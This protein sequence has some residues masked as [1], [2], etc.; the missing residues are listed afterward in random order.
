MGKSPSVRELK[1]KR[2]VEGLIKALEDG[3][4][5]VRQIAAKALGEIGDK[6][7]VEPL[8]RLLE[9]E[10]EYGVVL[11]TAVDALGN[12]GDKRAV[13]PLTRILECQ[14]I[15]KA[16][17][18]ALAR[19]TAG[20]FRMKK[21]ECPICGAKYDVWEGRKLSCEHCGAYL[22]VEQGQLVE[23]V[24]EK[25]TES[26]EYEVIVP[27][28]YIPRSPDFAHILEWPAFTL[29]WPIYCCICL[30]LVKESDFYG[31][32]KRIEGPV[33][34]EGGFV[35]QSQYTEIKFKIPYCKDCRH[36]VRKLFSRRE[37]EGVFVEPYYSFGY[38]MTLKFRNPQ[39]AAMFRQANK[40]II[41]E[42][43]IR[44]KTA[45]RWG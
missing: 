36:K 18:L 27:F 37:E 35:W 20:K 14:R 10:S 5:K 9:H 38:R 7:A 25:V 19:V 2:D 32:A 6:R 33:G 13:T 8:I 16:T 30:K 29:A 26:P 17:E 41:R 39:Y 15:R 23:I 45:A 22:S 40:E 11:R 42:V 34:Y 31:V 21:G 12:I 43:R 3:R 28:L 4:E 1:A 24:A 44:I